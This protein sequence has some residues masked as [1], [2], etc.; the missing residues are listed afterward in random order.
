MVSNDAKTQANWTDTG[1]WRTM[2][3]SNSRRSDY[4]Q[5][6]NEEIGDF[7]DIG[8]IDSSWKGKN[9]LKLPKQ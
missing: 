7:V 6:E 5:W 1:G 2:K 4:I 3:D 8:G 9:L